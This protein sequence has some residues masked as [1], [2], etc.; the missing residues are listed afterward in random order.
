M[1][2]LEKY[3]QWTLLQGKNRA[4]DVEKGLVDTAG[5]GEGGTHRESSIETLH[6]SAFVSRSATSDSWWL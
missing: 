5:E 4:T 3:Y 1:W 6:V 2:N